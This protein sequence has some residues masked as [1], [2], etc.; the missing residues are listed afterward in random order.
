MRRQE[1]G[2]SAS[3]K[4]KCLRRPT[5]LFTQMDVADQSS[6]PTR[7]A[8][9]ALMVL[10]AG[11]RLLIG[12]DLPGTS[13]QVPEWTNSRCPQQ[14]NRISQ[15]VHKPPFAQTGIIDSLYEV[16]QSHSYFSTRNFGK[17]RQTRSLCS[18]HRPDAVLLPVTYT[19]PGLQM[20]IGQ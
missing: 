13:L 12:G 5:G 3:K 14:P 16:S 17:P 7:Q 11:T 19:W 20:G 10:P 1:I 4:G 8:R 18:D 6:T 9:R 2:G 15:A